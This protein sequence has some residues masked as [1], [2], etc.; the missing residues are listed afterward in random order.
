MGVFRPAP[1]CLYDLSSRLSAAVGVY[2][3]SR[4]VLRHVVG[5][6]LPVNLVVDHGL[7]RGAMLPLQALA[8]L[9]AHGALVALPEGQPPAPRGPT[10]ELGFHAIEAQ[11]RV[12]RAARRKPRRA[13]EI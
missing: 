9:E 6:V 10:S 2:K 11:A 12:V 7:D 4:I 8:V 13:H 5:A 3:H 1:N